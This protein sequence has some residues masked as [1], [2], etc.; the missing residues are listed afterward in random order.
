MVGC[1]HKL[2]E[3]G[4]VNER[5]G[6]SERQRSWNALKLSILFICIKLV[7]NAN[8]ILTRESFGAQKVRVGRPE[9]L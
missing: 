5:R 3:K 4:V 7:P 6:E 1:V 2:F 9:P 8:D